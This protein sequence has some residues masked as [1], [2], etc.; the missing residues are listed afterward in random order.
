MNLRR[1]KK[2]TD[3]RRFVVVKG[4]FENEKLKLLSIFTFTS[5][6]NWCFI[7]NNIRFVNTFGSVH[8]ESLLQARGVSH[9]TQR[10]RR[11]A[12]VF[13]ECIIRGMRNISENIS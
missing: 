11:F 2:I 4:D 12:K 9:A 1:K 7:L 8:T 10:L 13:R 3:L 6:Y 5:Y